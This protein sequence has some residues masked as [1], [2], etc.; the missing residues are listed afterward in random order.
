[1]KNIQLRNIVLILCIYA[2]LLSVS[3]CNTNNSQSPS[4]PCNIPTGPGQ[5][6]SPTFQLAMPLSSEVPGHYGNFFAC[7]G[8]SDQVGVYY[9]GKSDFFQLQV[10]TGDYLL[11]YVTTM[12]HFYLVFRA[13]E[14]ALITVGLQDGDVVYEAMLYKG[15][16]TATSSVYFQHPVTLFSEPGAQDGWW[17]IFQK[18]DYSPG[19]MVLGGVGVTYTPGE[20]LVLVCSRPARYILDYTT[21]FGVYRV[22]FVTTTWFETVV[23]PL[24][25]GEEVLNA[26][27]T[28]LDI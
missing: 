3:G 8:Y 11:T 4:D 17:E 24:Q 13:T 12:G 5:P 7:E 14:S 18:D 27:I 16:V 25:P 20:S 28:I 2:L 6:S 22:E 21:N 9:D 1:M 15:T 26:Y 10:P 23:I 19:I